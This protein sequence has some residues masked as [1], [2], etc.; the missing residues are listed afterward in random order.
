MKEKFTLFFVFI[1]G[2]F[3]ALNAQ[4]AL[5][6]NQFVNTQI[7]GPGVY[8]VEP[9]QFYAFDGRIDLTFEIT[10]EGSDDSWIYEANNPPVLVNTP[11]ADGSPRDFFELKEGGAITVKNVLF[12]GTN[13]N[14]EIVK[15]IINNTA[16][17]HMIIDN[18]VI[19]DW[20]DFAFR[21]QFEGQLL[22]VTNSVF[23]NGMRPRYSQWGGF[24]VRMDVACEEVVFENNT[25]VN[26]GRLLANSGPFHNAN[27]HQI[28][29]TY[30]N[31]AVA[32]SLI[33]I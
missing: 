16:G 10:I 12:S 14:D 29:N 26:S 28:H 1:F 20:Q 33:H 13:S 31:Q 18:C 2:L 8:T 9:G 24:P 19:T 32:L 21:N 25:V 27:V 6:P 23:I 17:T 7:T 15:I 4:T 3:S 30:L 11:A 5:D 22:S